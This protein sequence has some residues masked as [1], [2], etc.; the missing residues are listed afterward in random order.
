MYIGELK[1]VEF[2]VIQGLQTLSFNFECIV[3]LLNALSNS[4]RRTSHVLIRRDGVKNSN[5]AKEKPE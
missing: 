3:V 2:L 5:G 4:A 1:R